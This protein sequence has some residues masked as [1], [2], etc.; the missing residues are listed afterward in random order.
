MTYGNYI[1][2]DLAIGLF[3]GGTIGMMACAILNIW[4]AMGM[5]PLLLII[6]LDIALAS[7]ALITKL[8]ERKK[9]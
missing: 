8:T 5:A 2:K 6:I 7:D 3:F 1:N 9:K 4:G